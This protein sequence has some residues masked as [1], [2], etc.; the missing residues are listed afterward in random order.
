MIDHQ[1]IDRDREELKKK[2]HQRDLY[3]RRVYG[4]SLSEYEQLLRHQGGGCFACGFMPR[5]DQNALHVDH[6][7]RTGFVRGLLCMSCNRTLGLLRGDDPRVC[8][9]LADYLEQ[10]PARSVIGRRP[11]PKKK[12]KRKV[13]KT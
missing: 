12:R 3:L 1:A 11:V 8:R 2:R 13:K 7:H 9:R 10:P 4:I 6:D 5:A